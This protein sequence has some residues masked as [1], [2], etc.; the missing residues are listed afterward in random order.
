[1]TIE[2]MRERK[3]ELGYSYEQLAEKAN[4]PLG[5]V[6]K[7]LGGFTKA[8]R[9]ATVEALERALT[10]EAPT[11][12]QTSEA[13]GTSAQSRDESK[14]YGYHVKES[15]TGFVEEMADSYG[16]A[17]HKTQ[18]NYNIRD[19]ELLSVDQRMELIEGVL[20]DMASPSMAHQQITFMMGMQISN[21]IAAKKGTC[22]TF[23]APT[24]VELFP[25]KPTIVQPDV[26]VICDPSII[27]KKRIYGAPNFV[28]EVL[29]DSTKS[30]DLFTK[31]EVYEKAGVREYWMIDYE[32]RQ[33]IMYG[34]EGTRRT[35]EDEKEE[36]LADVIPE[37][38]ARR[39]EIALRPME[40]KVPVDFGKGEFVID[41]D[42]ILEQLER[43]E[44]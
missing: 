27:K 5:T 1:M 36:K 15:K 4:L 11:S 25:G 29:S 21:Q 13:T 12:K 3:R 24:D 22:V 44:L 26:M 10:K 6:Q 33:I 23:M 31:S 18:G 14:N 32:K 34:F 9:R 7:V 42:P 2:E 41:F 38:K 19:Y 8:P 28:I 40:G 35:Q 39:F 17:S 37:A 16:Q 20:Y 30:K 43:L